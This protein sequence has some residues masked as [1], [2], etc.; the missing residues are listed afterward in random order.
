MSHSFM[1]TPVLAWE[2]KLL[3]L[4]FGIISFPFNSSLRPKHIPVH[5][6]GSKPQGITWYL[7]IPAM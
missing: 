4:Q 2:I 3:A 1:G 7:K 5:W 6:L